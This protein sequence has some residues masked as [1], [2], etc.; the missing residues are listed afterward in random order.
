MKK[1]LLSIFT[2]LCLCLTLLPTAAL[3]GEDAEA[4]PVC[5]CETACTAGEM[6]EDCPV[7][8]EEGASPEDCRAPAEPEGGHQHPDPGQLQRFG[9]QLPYREEWELLLL[10]RCVPLYGPGGSEP[11]SERHQHL[12]GRR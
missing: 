10:L 5:T 8:G 1:R 7:C 9:D 2:A 12:Q 3:A 6:A 11:C 4:A